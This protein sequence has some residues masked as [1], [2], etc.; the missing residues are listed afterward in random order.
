MNPSSASV[1]ALAEIFQP[2]KDELARVEEEFARHLHS[3]VELIPEMG[4]YVQMSG[5]KRVRPAVLLMAAR[6]CGY[7]GDRAVLNAAV[8][9]FIHTATL[10]H[11][12]II[13]IG[14]AHV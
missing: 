7:T 11:D 8:V 4:K 5:G 12:D 6:L 3:R 2:V 1:P 10:V 13:E 9:E 14:R